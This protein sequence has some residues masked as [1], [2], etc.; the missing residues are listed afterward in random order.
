MIDRKE[1]EDIANRWVAT[2][3]TPLHLRVPMITQDIDA[4]HPDLTLLE[5]ERVEEQARE[6]RQELYDRAMHDT[7]G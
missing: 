4:A 2:L 1:I 3:G 7:W 5:W 6:V